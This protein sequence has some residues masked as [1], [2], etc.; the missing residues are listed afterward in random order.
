LLKRS[1][2]RL[3]TPKVVTDRH[4]LHP[5]AYYRRVYL[6]KAM[7]NGV[8]HMARVLKTSKIAIVN[9]LI[10]R[11]ISSLL[12]EAIIE[13]A[14]AAI[15]AAEAGKRYWHNRAVRELRKWAEENG[16]DISKF[17]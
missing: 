11:G 9:E 10:A 3:F 6:S 4:K 12:G 7:F 16:Y 14:R 13:D 8:E 1:I 17:T 5:D 2:T 15:A